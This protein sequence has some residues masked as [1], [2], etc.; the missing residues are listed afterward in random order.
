M[1][2]I[3]RH[4]SEFESEVKA[5]GKMGVNNCAIGGS[6]VLQ[7]YGLRIWAEPGDLD[8]VIFKPTDEQQE[9]VIMHGEPPC[10]ESNS[11]SPDS[12]HVRS[13]KIDRN[14]MCLNFLLHAEEKPE[15]NTLMIFFKEG[16]MV[17]S[18]QRIDAILKAKAAY[19]RQKDIDHFEFLKANNFVIAPPL[20][21]ADEQQK[22]SSFLDS[23]DDLPF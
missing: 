8:F 12:E 2:F 15:T 16:H 9:F 20:Q 13:Y 18:A 22:N 17:V 7:K 11:P 4:L 5:L 14:G 19:G 23:D 1:D 6:A 21:K 10:G 3:E